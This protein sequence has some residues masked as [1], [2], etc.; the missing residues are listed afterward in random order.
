MLS[1]A[2]M[3]PIRRAL[4]VTGELS[5]HGNVNP[6]GGIAEKLYAAQQHGRKMVIIP[7]ANAQELVRLREA[8]AHLD[9]RPVQTLADAVAL[10]FEG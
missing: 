3:R 9:V 2:T 4:A 10:A 8:T 6:V 1:A 7:A 5:I